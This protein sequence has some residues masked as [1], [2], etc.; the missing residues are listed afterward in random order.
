ME[1]I[2]EDKER[3][4]YGLLKIGKRESELIN[5]GYFIIPKKD[6]SRFL[7]YGRDDERVI[8]DVKKDS[9]LLFHRLKDGESWYNQDIAEK[10]NGM[11]IDMNLEK[12]T[13]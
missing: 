13:A 11:I 3:K 8:Y 2:N 5:R 9:V 12:I 6:Y 7:I 4:E 1:N 10:K